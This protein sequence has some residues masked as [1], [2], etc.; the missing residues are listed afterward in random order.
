MRA[1]ALAVVVLTA[2]W[3][4]TL[5]STYL[6]DVVLGLVVATAVVTAVPGTRSV[7][8]EGTPPP[9]GRR[10]LAFP[11]F[12]LATLREVVVGTWDV[13]LRVL[14]LRPVDRPGI[15]LVPIGE[16]TSAGLAAT[17]LADTLSPGEVLID[18][19]HE[20]GVMLVHVIDARDP[21][22]VRAR[23]QRFYERHQRGVFP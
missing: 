10:L 16:R 9:L 6:L 2:L 11:R 18:V 15:V 19:D 23:H 1:R 5:A 22:E 3:M 14:H 7:I 4:L 13:T 17:A 12:A 20:R 21:D 8:S